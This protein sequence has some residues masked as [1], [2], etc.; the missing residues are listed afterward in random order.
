M[1]ISGDVVLV[2]GM[3]H[4]GAH[5][6]LLAQEFES[7]GA[8]VHAP[9]L[10]RGSLIADT[11]AMQRIV[12]TCP[13][14]PVVIGH[15]YG[16]AVIT[17]LLDVRALV[18]LAAFVPTTDESC[19]SIGGALVDEAIVPHPDGGTIVRPEAARVAL[20]ADADDATAAW[21][22]ALLVRQAAG[23]GRGHPQRAAWQSTPSL[24]VVCA[25]DRAVDPSVQRAMA[26]RCSESVELATDHS[27]Y[28]SRPREIADIVRT[29]L[30]R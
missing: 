7:F 12:D 4:Q 25:K 26:L 20:C 18:Y 3:W 23:H 15:S 13:S 11:Y 16:G 14:P 30:D 22:S 1:A 17:G 6:R 10:H 24:Y 5:M 8:R 28:V 21:A 19:A 27:P 2:H 29:W 9:D